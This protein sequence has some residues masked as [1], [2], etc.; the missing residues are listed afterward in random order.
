MR[1]AA[2]SV[3]M[4]AF[5]LVGCATEPAALTALPE[6]VEV[7]VYQTRL[8]RGERQLEIRIVNGTEEN[9]HITRADFDSTQLADTAHWIKDS[10]DINAGRTI[11]LRVL[12]PEAQCDYEGAPTKQ[13]TIGFLLE[14]GRSGTAR[15]EPQD[16][17]GQVPGL[18]AEDCLVEAV[19]EHAIIS[20]SGDLRYEPGARTPAVLEL[21]VE[22]T[23]ARGELVIKSV[24]NTI[25][26]TIVNDPAVTNGFPI[27]IGPDSRP[28]LLHIG[29]VATLCQAH[30][31]ADDKRGT[32]FPIIV[33]LDGVQSTM[34]FAV[35]DS[36]KN[37]LYSFIGDYC[38]SRELVPES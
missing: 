31:I 37:Q 27:P 28:S 12:L 17:I 20:V 24:E 5:A 2:I 30:A 9:L 1:I 32:I 15:I 29:V 35:G 22:P 14:D 26:L 21:S 33:E 38:L 34:Y 7:S 11:D 4:S 16:P 19:E 6:G 3:A 13:V 8:D 36:M 23:G 10:T 25:L 18:T